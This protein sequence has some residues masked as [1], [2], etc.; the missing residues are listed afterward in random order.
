MTHKNAAPV[1]AVLRIGRT[2]MA[3]APTELR[4]QVEPSGRRS[5]TLLSTKD[6]VAVG[7]CRPTAPTDPYVRTLP[8]TVHQIM[9]S[10]PNV[11]IRSCFVDTVVEF[12]CIRRVSQERFHDSTPRF[13]PLAPTGC[14]SPASSV[15]SRRYDFLP[16][17]PPRFVAF[18]W[19]YLGC[20]RCV[21]S[22]VDKCA[23]E[24]WSW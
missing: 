4:A 11:A 10:L 24:A 8:H 1:V 23:A 12:R 19:R 18:A 14:C 13:P 17:I 15:L 5:C 6:R 7:R 9:G 21:C 22:S 2:P 16:P 20:T 3:N